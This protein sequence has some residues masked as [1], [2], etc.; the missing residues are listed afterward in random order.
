L[1]VETRA[2][3][4]CLCKTPGLH[5]TIVVYNAVQPIVSVETDI[6]DDVGI[7]VTQIE[8]GLLIQNRHGQP[9]T[10]NVVNVLGTTVS[11]TTLGSDNTW[12]LLDSL[13]RGMYYAVVV[14]SGSHQVTKIE[15]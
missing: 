1:I 6:H 3:G 8:G 12:L 13:P 15:L 5:D 9:G 7:K 11:T 4:N 2:T 10:V 14:V